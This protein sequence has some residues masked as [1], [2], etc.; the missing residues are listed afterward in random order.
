MKFDLKPHLQK[1]THT[2]IIYFSICLLIPFII[3]MYYYPDNFEVILQSIKE[4]FI[5]D[6]GQ[7]LYYTFL[8][9]VTS[10]VIIYFS[11][12][13]N[14]EIINSD[15]DSDVEMEDNTSTSTSNVNS[16][17]NATQEN[18][19]SNNIITEETIETYEDIQIIYRNDPQLEGQ[20][21]SHLRETFQRRNIS[22]EAPIT[23][24]LSNRTSQVC[25]LDENAVNYLRADVHNVLNFDI[26]NHLGT[27]TIARNEFGD[28]NEIIVA[29]QPFDEDITT[30]DEYGQVITGSEPPVSNRSSHVNTTH[31]ATSS[32][33]SR[34]DSS[35]NSDSSSSD[36]SSNSDDSGQSDSSNSSVE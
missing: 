31:S 24:R 4:F 33:S 12:L 25:V 13:F 11:I 14:I 29:W 9:S 18:N 35:S 16:N 2:I 7:T 5:S 36:S 10:N 17:V 20:P 34:S 28:A 27:R 6:R 30:L 19:T 23:V 26:D 3:L 8:H 22:E 32:D 21:E 1:K 15:S